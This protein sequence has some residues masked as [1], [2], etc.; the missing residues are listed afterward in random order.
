MKESE[1]VSTHESKLYIISLVFSILFWFIAIVGTLGI[2]LIYLL[3][4]ALFMLVA[5]AGFIAYI[6]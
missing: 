6:Q 2:G 1:L 4:V 3:F 5:H